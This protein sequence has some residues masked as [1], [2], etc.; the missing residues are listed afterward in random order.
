MSVKAINLNTKVHERYIHRV[1][2]IWFRYLYL[3]LISIGFSSLHFHKGMPEVHSS[4]CPKACSQQTFLVCGGVVWLLCGAHPKWVLTFR[5]VFTSSLSVL[6]WASSRVF[7]LV[8]TPMISRS[9]VFK[10]ITACL[11]ELM[12]LQLFFF[13][14]FGTC[15]LL[16]RNY[17]GW[18][19]WI[20]LRILS[21]LLFPYSSY[22]LYLSVS[23]ILSTCL[24]L[25]LRK[26]I[27]IN[28]YVYH[29]MCVCVCVCVC[30]QRCKSTSTGVFKKNLLADQ[31]SFVDTF[32][33]I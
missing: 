32:I 7:Y 20:T 12:L 8:P 17:Y 28:I 33:I 11:A 15:L 31:V 13:F 23:K 1:E 21:Q 3:T 19:F 4:F 16:S 14:Y 29:H 2:L 24:S 5:D 25:L 27:Y 18:H 6:D 22:S 10:P 26:N 30:A 9:S